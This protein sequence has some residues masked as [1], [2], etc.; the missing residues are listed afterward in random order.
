MHENTSAKP[1]FECIETQVTNYKHIVVS[2]MHENTSANIEIP[3]INMSE[4]VGMHE[5]P[6]TNYKHFGSVIVVM[7]WNTSANIDVANVNT[8]TSVVM[9]SKTSANIHIPG[10]NM[11]PKPHLE[12]I[13]TPVTNYKHLGDSCNA[14]EHVGQH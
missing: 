14:L 9:D 7:H 13:E 12:C 6:V 11:S 1:H 3:H 8:S 2:L 4:S 5:T 10:I